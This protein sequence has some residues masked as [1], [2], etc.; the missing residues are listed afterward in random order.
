MRE[1][2]ERRNDGLAGAALCGAAQTD[3][4]AHPRKAGVASRFGALTVGQRAV[5]QGYLAQMMGI[6]FTDPAV[7]EKSL[8][9]R[10]QTEDQP[11]DC[12]W[13]RLALR[14]APRSLAPRRT[15]MG[16]LPLRR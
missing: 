10:L 8:G 3:T 1:E 5:E 13:R 6:V 4:L 7:E 2:S 11:P 14:R 12:A 15:G 9:M 16:A